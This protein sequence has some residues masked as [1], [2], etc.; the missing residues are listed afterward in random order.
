MII[1]VLT[2]L[3]IYGLSILTIQVFIF[4]MQ[5]MCIESVVPSSH[6]TSNSSILVSAESQAP[7]AIILIILSVTTFMILVESKVERSVIDVID[8]CQ[9]R[10]RPGSKRTTRSNVCTTIGKYIIRCGNF[11][12]ATNY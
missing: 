10:V 2:L 7:A 11:G 6:I 9:K 12:M 1:E 4:W 8:Q 5:M 3:Y